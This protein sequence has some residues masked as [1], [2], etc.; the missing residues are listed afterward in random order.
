MEPMTTNEVRAAEV[1]ASMCLA[2]DLGMGF[3]FEHGLHATLTTM[4]LCE[5]LGVDPV[6]DTEHHDVGQADQQRAHA[7]SIRFQAGGLLE[8]RRLQTSL[9]IAEPLRRVADL[10]VRH[11]T[12]KREAPS[13]FASVSVGLFVMVSSSFRDVL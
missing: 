5:I 2:T 1:I 13:S 12:L 4:R 8:T 7:R 9:R 6:G 3:P 11:P 10:P